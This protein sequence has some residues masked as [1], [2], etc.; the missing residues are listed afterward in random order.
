MN[1]I[2]VHPPAAPFRMAVLACGL[3][4]LP[5]CLE[6]IEPALTGDGGCSGAT[7][8]DWNTSAYVLPFPVGQTYGV[9]LGNCSASY[10]S[11]GQPDEFAYDFGMEIGTVITAS[12]PGTVVFV[13]ESGFDGGFPNNLAVVDHGDGTLGAYMHLTHEGS[14]VEE[15]DEVT[16][17]DT[18]GWSGN[19]GLAGY[20]H[21]HFV[22]VQS[23][24]EWPYRSLP[25]TFRNTQPNPTGLASY[26]PYSALPYD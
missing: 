10:H 4:I 19:T 5:A 21:L 15:G 13:E 16:R 20:P 8:P 12:R 25:V 23:P 17:G 14:R 3:A 6:P 22:V 1:S 18:I 9:N 7:Y 11:Q 2:R 26:T 24:G